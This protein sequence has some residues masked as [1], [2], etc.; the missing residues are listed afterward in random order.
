MTGD[1]SV[2]SEEYV[3]SD[4]GVSMNWRI[5]LANGLVLTGTKVADGVGEEELKNLCRL[6]A[7]ASFAAFMGVDSTT[8][9]QDSERQA[10]IDKY[11]E[12]MGDL[13]LRLDNLKRGIESDDFDEAQVLPLDH[14]IAQ[15]EGY[16]VVL[17]R[18]INRMK[19]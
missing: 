4:D 15:L 10:L 18:K 8:L 11:E 1:H 19:L 7:E 13:R 14:Q 2:V 16:M 12:S 3:I 17:R 5:T 6:D 9:V